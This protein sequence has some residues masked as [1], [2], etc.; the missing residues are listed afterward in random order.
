MPKLSRSAMRRRSVVGLISLS[1]IVLSAFDSGAEVKTPRKE[2]SSFSAAHCHGSIAKTEWTL[3]NGKSPTP[4]CVAGKGVLDFDANEDQNA[5]VPFTL[6]GQ[7]TGRLNVRIMWQAASTIGSVGWCVEVLART[8][9]KREGGAPL[10]QTARNCTSDPAKKSTEHLN[11]VLAINVAGTP[12]AA[13][14]DP[15]HIGVSRDANSSVVLDDMP[16]DAR[17]IG[18]VIETH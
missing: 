2:E 12:A 1:A 14:T 11:T 3:A 17:L 13:N 18:V 4:A 7:F 10:T 16:G 15:L 6:P 9:L 5:I 8:D